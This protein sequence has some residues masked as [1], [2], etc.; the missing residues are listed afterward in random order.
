M[1]KINKL[2]KST[3]VI[4]ILSFLLVA[5]LAFGGTYAYFSDAA[6]PVSGDITMG[7]LTVA[8][9][10]GEGAVE[11]LGEITVAQPN[12]AIVDGTTYTI[13]TTGST[14]DSYVRVKVTAVLD[15]VNYEDNDQGDSHINAT[16]IFT[17]TAGDGW[18]LHTD[19]YLYM[20]SVENATSAS[21]ADQVTSNAGAELTLT[22][23][24]NKEVGEDGSTFFMGATGEYSITVEAIQA[25]YV[26][27]LTEDS[28]ITQVASAWAS[29]K[30]Q[31]N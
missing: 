9:N 14:I 25:D 29:V 27:G 17:I 22:I 16:N 23:K 6:G 8:L 7:T 26:E 19:G 12:Q 11:A 24:V 15:S 18:V 20:S 28:T 31:K 30:S 2:G 5:V 10:D 21:K 3:F 1:S 4:A 13:A